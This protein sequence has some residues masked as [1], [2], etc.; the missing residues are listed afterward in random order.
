MN[1]QVALENRAAVRWTLKSTDQGIQ[2]AT[3]AKPNAIAVT[4]RGGSPV[5]RIRLGFVRSLQRP[6]GATRH[7]S[8]SAE[9]PGSTGRFFSNRVPESNSVPGALS[10]R[11]THI[12]DDD[13][14]RYYLGMLSTTSKL[15]A[16]EEHLLVCPDCVVRAEE[17]QD[18]VDAIRAAIIVGG[19]DQEVAIELEPATQR[20]ALHASRAGSA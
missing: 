3:W 13:L 12:S 19:Y 20:A 2:M 6:T 14:E 5:L 9:G 18:Y 10:N 16:M 8:D 4:C 15:A 7:V 11:M 17:M 1:C